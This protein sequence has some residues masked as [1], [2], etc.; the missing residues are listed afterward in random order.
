[1]FEVKQPAFLMIPGESKKRI[2]H[3]ATVCELNDGKVF[4][5]FD[6]SLLPMKVGTEVMLYA[7]VRG[8]F[9]QT[10][11]T[12]VSA[13]EVDGKLVCSFAPVGDPV[14]A[15]SRG[16]YRI[17]IIADNVTATLGKFSACPVADVSPEGFSLLLDISLPVGSTFDATINA[18]ET[19][20]TG[21]V[22]LQTV[23]QLPT[24]QFRYGLL[25][26]ETKSP[27]RKSLQK[28]SMDMQRSRL[29]RMSRAA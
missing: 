14:S 6:E 9:T 25:A 10:G 5:V 24:G 15:E 18:G 19:S 22:R 11:A 3:P 26:F 2:L 13:G 4:C 21:K 29:K 7:D 28:L 20:L 17:S 16:S 12:L 27:F 23:K 1:M 8:K